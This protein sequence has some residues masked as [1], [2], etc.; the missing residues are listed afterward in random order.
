[1]IVVDTSAILDALAA[2]EPAPGLVQR[3]ADDGDL[4]APHL[5][6]IETLHALRT[7]RMREQITAERAA[8]VRSDFGETAIVRYPHEPLS[9]RIWELRHNLSAYDAAFVA[10]AEALA[11]PLVTCDGR[12]ASSSG[13]DARVELFE[14]ARR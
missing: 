14:V 10:L 9:D 6:D 2:R 4:H 11:V 12:L 5:I 3:L 8:D 1:V 7:M 13:H